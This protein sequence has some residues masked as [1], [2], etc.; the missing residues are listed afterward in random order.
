M[1]N[2]FFLKW[3]AQYDSILSRLNLSKIL[4]CLTLS[5]YCSVLKSIEFTQIVKSLFV[6]I[7]FH[8]K[9]KKLFKIA[10][11]WIGMA[12]YTSCTKIIILASVYYDFYFKK[13]A[14]NFVY[15]T[16][17]LVFV[18]SKI[19]IKILMFYV[20]SRKYQNEGVYFSFQFYLKFSH[21]ISMQN[22]LKTFIQWFTWISNHKLV[23]IF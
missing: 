10:Q 4:N 18:I 21:H 2:Y 17:S 9:T 20:V 19:Y 12:R 1:A 7:R 6:L 23:N 14:V 11:F 22:F 15:N 13:F 5:Q 8:S 16:H 3:V